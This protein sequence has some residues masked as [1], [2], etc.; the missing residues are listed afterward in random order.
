MS[1]ALTAL[2]CDGCGAPVPLPTEGPRARCAHCGGGADVPASHRDRQAELAEARGALRAAEDQWRELPRPLPLWVAAVAPWLILGGLP[3][4]IAVNVL[5]WVFWG[6]YPTPI[7]MLAL[8]IFTPIFAVIYFG[9]DAGAKRA[10]SWRVNA[11]S[12]HRTPRGWACRRCG[13]PLE[14]EAGALAASCGY[15]GADSVLSDP[16]PRWRRWLEGEQERAES[17]L[18]EAV[19]ALRESRRNTRL[20][21][22]VVLSVLT[23]FWLFFMWPLLYVWFFA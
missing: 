1:D 5:G 6:W 18:R 7:H 20:T 22:I 8:G 10:Y 13:A 4:F 16:G 12:A 19:W 9:I 2:A 15:C 21:R 11:M 3:V 23:P 14:L 17:S